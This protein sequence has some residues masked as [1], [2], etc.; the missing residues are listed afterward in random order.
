MRV[1]TFKG[2]FIKI[3]NNTFAP[4]LIIAGLANIRKMRVKQFEVTH[5]SR[6][7][8]EVSIKKWGLFKAAFK[9]FLQTIS[10]RFK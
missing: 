4:N 8:G 10:F 6:Q 3:P 5:Y 2:E 7:T 9:S 1:S